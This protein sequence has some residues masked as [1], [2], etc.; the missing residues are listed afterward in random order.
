MPRWSAALHFKW[1]A[2][3]T[4]SS[5]AARLAR[6]RCCRSTN[7]SKCY[8]RPERSLA[9]ERR[10]AVEKIVKTFGAAYDTPADPLSNIGNDSRTQRLVEERQH[11]VNAKLSNNMIHAG[12]ATRGSSWRTSSISSAASR[13][14]ELR[15]IEPLTYSVLQA[16]VS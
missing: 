12:T 13:R 11:E 15:G 2:A 14:V 6:G 10:K 1:M 3:V 4:E 5:P 16:R 9:G 8:A 7:S